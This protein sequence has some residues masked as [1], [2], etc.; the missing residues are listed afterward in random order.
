MK[1]TVQELIAIAYTYFPRA[2]LTSDPRFAGTP[3]AARQRAACDAASRRYG[4][5]REVLERLR[6]RFPEERF[7]GISVVD[8]SPF[9]QVAGA[10]PFLDRC[11]TGRLGLPPRDAA[12]KSHCLEI[13]VSFVVPYY[14]IYS[15][16]IGLPRE[17]AATFG[18]EHRRRFDLT[19]DEQPFAEAMVQEIGK[20]F[21][22]HEPISP[23]IGFAVVPDVQA[24]NKWFGE[25]TVFTCLFSHSL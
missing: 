24:G 22:D 21:P 15:Y 17:R 9:L 12:E 4:A 13:L 25:S 3:E 11:F 5:W 6:H 19:A 20:A 1:H 23:E 8:G 10:E 7:P 18:G 2:M 16:T 14:T